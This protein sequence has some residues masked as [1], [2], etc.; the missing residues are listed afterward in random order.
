[1]TWHGAR[2]YLN[3]E[4]LRLHGASLQEDAPGHGDALTPGDENTLIA[5]LKAIGANGVRSQ[6]PLYPGLLEK[7]D[8]AGILVWQGIGP[9]EE[10][11]GAAIRTAPAR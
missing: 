7:L 8:A 11:T 4:R 3:G 6:H 9:V 5:E 10:R 1:L 2:V